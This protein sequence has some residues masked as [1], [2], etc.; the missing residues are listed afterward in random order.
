[1]VF[2]EAYLAIIICC[3]AAAVPADYILFDAVNITV[4]GAPII[5][6]GEKSAVGM[7]GYGTGGL[8]VTLGAMLMV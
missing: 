6:L 4:T 5:P 1:M 2:S 7:D 3:S 8:G